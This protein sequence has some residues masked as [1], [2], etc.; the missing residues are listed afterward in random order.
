MDIQK[1]IVQFDGMFNKRLIS[2][3]VDYISSQEL[4]QMGIFKKGNCDITDI[5]NVKGFTCE[6]NIPIQN[7][8]NKDMSK[9]VFL[10]YIHKE[11][12]VHLINYKT[13]F[14]EFNY[15]D[16]SQT[17]FLRYEANGKYEIH[18][19]NAPGIYRN[20]S[21][22]VNLNEGYEGGDFVFF[23]PFNKKDIIH[24]VSL[25]TGSVLMF[26]SNFLFPHSIKPIIKGT[27]YSLVCWLG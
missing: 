12:F 24:R 14:P 5:R 25:K 11:L 27:R 1:A 19:H 16:I 18:V 7:I 3:L 13:K 8:T 10:R 20:L 15:T 22:I 17:D 6:S 21:I 23:D 4:S 26:P 2:R 9:Y